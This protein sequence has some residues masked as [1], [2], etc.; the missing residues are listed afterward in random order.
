MLTLLLGVGAV[1]RAGAAA[2]QPAGHAHA[3][4][5][6]PAELGAT[7]Q[8]AGS[9]RAP[10]F[11]NLGTHHHEIKTASPQAQRYFDQGLRLVYGFNHDEA[12]R[13][14][15][16][17]ARLDPQC[18][19]AWWGVAL[20]LGPNINLPI[21][22]ERNRAAYEA[23]QKALA[24]QPQASEREAAYIQAL[25][26]RYSLAP[27]ASRDD[28]DRAYARAMGDV[29]R[30]YPDDLDAA[31]LYAESLMDLRP[32]RLWTPDGKP[33]EGTAEIVAVLESVLKRSPDHPGANHYYIHAVE[34]SPHPERALPSARRLESLVPGAGHLVHMPA[35]IYMRTGDYA[36]ATKSNQAAAVV[37]EAYIGKSSAQG[38]YPLMYY[39]HNL[40]F[41]AIAAAMGGES[42]VA[43]QAAAR[44]L[45]NVGPAV[46]EMP[47]GEFMMPTPIYVALRFQR[48]DEILQYPEPSGDMQTTH[49]L[50]RYARA[51]AH[52]AKGDLKSSQAEREAFAA[53]RGKVPAGWMFNLNGARDVLS[54]AAAVLEARL[55]AAQGN[56]AAAIESWSKA[57]EAE[58]ALA[59]DEPPIWY[60]P[61]RE[62]LG[63]ELLRAG[64]FGEAEEVF[65]ADLE[66]N[67]HNGRS[68][69]GLW[70]SL[71]ARKMP[72]EA[73]AARK[74]FEAAWKNADV[75][76]QVGDL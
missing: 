38:I 64:R 41:L 63:G 66:R 6:A 68:L 60:Y 32:W 40:H 27:D 30:R 31:T 43:K 20:T 17:A 2:A 19:M 56:R 26:K 46:E 49:A 18:A 70:K 3:P 45:A 25:A 69:F 28:L 58:D 37:D 62:S 73:E 65:R 72:A 10:L 33:A 74:E 39:G 55:A 47:M 23:I 13:A 29:S 71:E 61:V 8:P 76:L 54:V 16:E 35:H 5:A 57:A 52:A 7:A 48:W 75:T 53:E 50:W 67:P 9:A 51:L 44:L 11:D 15:R 1:A 24:L 14:F 59:Y 34:A 4:A 42:A 36:A 12:E 21:D 22:P